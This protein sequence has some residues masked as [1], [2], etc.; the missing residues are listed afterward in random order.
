MNFASS[1]AVPVAPGTPG[2]GKVTTG[3]VPSHTTEVLPAVAT[4]AGTWVD[5]LTEKTGGSW[6]PASADFSA[7][8]GLAHRRIIRSRVAA[9]IGVAVPLPLISS[10]PTIS[11]FQ[12][13]A[14]LRTSMVLQ[15]C[16]LG[17]V[18]VI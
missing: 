5:G 3:F 7:P 2:I 12:A 18:P 9:A 4:S 8:C 13:Y 14:P 1:V 15:L 17:R 16:P 10:A 11:A 6:I